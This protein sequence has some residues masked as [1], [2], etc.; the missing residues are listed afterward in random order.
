MRVG[1]DVEGTVIKLLE[2]VQWHLGS[3]IKRTCQVTEVGA[4]ENCRQ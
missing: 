3:R 4:G 1:T 2:W